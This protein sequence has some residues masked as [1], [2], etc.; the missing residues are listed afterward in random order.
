MTGVQTCALPIYYSRALPLDD[1]SEEH[2]LQRVRDLLNADAT[3]EGALNLVPSI[4]SLDALRDG[5][6]IDSYASRWELIVFANDPQEAAEIAD[7]WAEA[8]VE[9]L[10]EA[11][12]GR[13]HV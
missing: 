2:A 9:A 8:G 7:A 1:A 5:L 12:I 13:A 4:G 10:R 6:R 11:E 3:L